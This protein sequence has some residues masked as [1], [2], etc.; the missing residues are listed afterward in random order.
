MSRKAISYIRWSSGSQTKGSTAQR[1][2]KLIQNYLHD[3]PDVTLVDTFKDEAVSSYHGK[4]KEKSLG[5]LLQYLKATPNQIDLIL[6]ESIDRLGRMDHIELITTI[7][8][9]LDHAD[10]HTLEDNQTYTRKRI[11]SDQSCL[12]LLAGSVSTAHQY[13]QKLSRR[14]KASYT[15]K[16]QKAA[17]GHAIK[18]RTPFWLT[19]SGELI[20]DKVPIIKDM[21]NLYLQG[22]G[23]RYIRNHCIDV[24]QHTIATTSLRR[25]LANP[26]LIGKWDGHK[27]WKAVIPDSTYY[28]LQN[29]LDERSRKVTRHQN[30][31]LSGLVQCSECGYNYS[32]KREKGRRDGMLCAGF[33]RNGKRDCSNSKNI[34]VVVLD[35]IYKQ[36]HHIALSR[37]LQ[38]QIDTKASEEVV[39]IDGQIAEIDEQIN[40]LVA[41]VKVTGGIDAIGQQINDLQKQKEELLT[42]RGTTEKSLGIDLSALS[43]EGNL[44]TLLQIANYKIIG[45]HGKFTVEDEYYTYDGYKRI[46]KSGTQYL[47]NGEP[48]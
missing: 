48:I 16:R 43:I 20:P 26:A 39:V 22:H 19:S 45:S 31:H 40:N 12:F 46:G 36:T 44:N 2:T 28:Q 3:H 7:S 13:S 15:A 30:H 8:S 23:D 25:W 6:V 9:I 35:Y 1:Q 21:V 4:H 11:R 41:L 29:T 47:V 32:I 38:K 5:D 34:P 10:I 27:V 14:I 18:L 42:Q 37:I 17:D 33:A 24:H